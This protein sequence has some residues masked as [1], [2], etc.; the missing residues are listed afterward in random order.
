MDIS[1]I[2]PKMDVERMDYSDLEDQ[3][4]FLS[5]KLEVLQD[6]YKRV[7]EEMSRRDHADQDSD[8]RSS[9]F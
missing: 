3:A 8:F 7:K 4:D 6:F 2:D 1:D 5:E 9:R